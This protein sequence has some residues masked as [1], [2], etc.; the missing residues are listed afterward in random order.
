MKTLT[1]NDFG[2]K[3]LVEDCQKIRIDD[4]LKSVKDKWKDLLLR[5]ELEAAGINIDLT[6]SKTL[7][8]GV[9]FWFK[10]PLCESRV[11]VIYQH[12]LD[13]SVGCRK[14][15]NL[16]YSKRRYKGMIEE[17]YKVMV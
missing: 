15:L 10:C 7:Y 4:T 2:N 3:I 16:D 13:G 14:C 11:G 8:D 12:P 5:A 1:A 17:T 9:R 6:T